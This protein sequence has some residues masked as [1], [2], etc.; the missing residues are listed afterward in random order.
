M[1]VTIDVTGL[2]P[3]NYRFAPSALAEL[4]AALHLLAEPAH[5]P[6]RSGWVAAV[7]TAVEPELLDR[8]VEMDYLWRT[9]RSDMFMPAS[10]ST[11][12]RI[13]LDGLD[14]LSDELW[15][16]AALITS[17]C[18]TV[19]LHRELGSP[20]VDDRARELARERAASRGPRQ[21]AFV[22]FVLEHPTDARSAVR[23]LLE[24][25]DRQF[26]A[27]AWERIVVDLTADA[28]LKSDLLGAYG[29]ERALAAVSSAITLNGAGN[30]IVVDKLQDNGTSANG[31]NVT[32]LPSAF[33]HPHL[34]VVH[35]PGWNPVIQYPAATS[36]L[37]DVVALEDIQLRMRALDHPARLRI[38]RSLLR[39]QRTTAELADAWNLSAPEVSRHLATLKEAGIVSS[40]RSGRYVLYSLDQDAVARF[41]IDLLEALQR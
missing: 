21:S 4:S 22:D 35:A 5:H 31:G 25:S 28:R 12:L 16:G 3:R 8:L 36:A 29:L 13:E 10:P 37:T 39:G 27:R 7:M 18:G 34:M 26:F 38:A 33:G 20:L 19:T 30:R 2:E 9:S 32:L 23:R 11:S 24:D 14:Q 40:T 6:T 17:S 1:S 41:G 15:V